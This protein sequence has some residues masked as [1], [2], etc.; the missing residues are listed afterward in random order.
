MT[1]HQLNGAHSMWGGE[2]VSSSRTMSPPRFELPPGPSYILRQL[3]SWK[4]VSYGAFVG[5][6]RVGGGTLGID[7]P[8]RTIVSCSIA[9]LPA[10]LYAQAEFQYWSTKRKA[11][12]LGARLAPK[13]PSKWPAGTD[14]I[15]TLIDVFKTGYLGKS[16]DWVSLARWS[17]EVILGDTMV[18][19]LA[20]GGQ[21]MD[22]R[23][24]GE[25][26]V[27]L[28]ITAKLI[29]LI[30]IVDRD[31]GAAVYQGNFRGSRRGS[32]AV[33]ILPFLDR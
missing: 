4:A 19:W 21:T 15:A 20:E 12:S 33:L 3:L 25:S 22:M 13:I 7:P 29:T 2:A 26:R 31:N 27:G 30:S 24:L 1:T 28:L 23:A 16:H 14:L 6:V 10:I 9:I 8:L 32:A 17:H 5:C 11:E 18:D